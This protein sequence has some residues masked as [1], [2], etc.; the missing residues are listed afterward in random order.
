MAL[1][2]NLHFLAHFVHICTQHTKLQHDKVGEESSDK[3][4]VAIPLE[5]RFKRSLTI[6]L[7]LSSNGSPVRE[8]HD[9]GALGFELGR[10]ESL[11]VLT[12]AIYISN[13]SSFAN[14]SSYSRPPRMYLWFLRTFEFLVSSNSL[15]R[16]AKASIS[17]GS[18]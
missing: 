13:L 2:K 7:R 11:E 10:R 9:R 17:S 16:W 18:I 1:L 4:R 8:E 15:M 5:C 3:C 14:R 12:V 6:S